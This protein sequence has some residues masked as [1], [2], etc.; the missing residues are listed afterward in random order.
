MDATWTK[1]QPFFKPQEKHTN[2]LSLNALKVEN[3]AVQAQYP[4]VP[5]P[6]LAPGSTPEV[7]SEIWKQPV[8]VHG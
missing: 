8:S 2:A 5:T 3:F 4:R 1:S 7:A 6:S